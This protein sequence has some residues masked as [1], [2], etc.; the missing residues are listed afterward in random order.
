M[1]VDNACK[2]E[3]EARRRRAKAYW[4]LALELITTGSL[5]KNKREMERV[6]INISSLWKWRCNSK[7]DARGWR[8]TA[9]FIQSIQEKFP[10]ANP[11]ALQLINIPSQ[12]TVDEVSTALFNALS[13]ER[14]IVSKL[15]VLRNNHA[16]A[17]TKDVIDRIQEEILDANAKLPQAIA[18]DKKMQKPIVSAVKTSADDWIA[19]VRVSNKKV[20][21]ELMRMARSRTGIALNC[22]E[23]APHIQSAIDQAAEKLKQAE[24]AY[25]VHPSAKNKEKK[26]DGKKRLDEAR[27]GLRII[28]DSSVLSSVK[29]HVTMS[30]AMRTRGGL[31]HKSKSHLF[32]STT[33]SIAL[34]NETLAMIIPRLKDDQSNLDRLMSVLEKKT[35]RSDYLSQ[36]SGEFV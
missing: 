6:S 7:E 17:K 29:L 5:S 11:N 22:K 4:H 8:P 24:A 1:N 18:N 20:H 35:D 19:F 31:V 13:A 15:N 16:K 32:E 3:A 27:A 34:A 25:N 9:T 23:T 12:V 2:K 26:T 14:K 21:E 10:W 33:A 30:I 36:K 28:A